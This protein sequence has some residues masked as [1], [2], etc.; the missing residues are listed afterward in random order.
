MTAEHTPRYRDAQ[1]NA[2]MKDLRRDVR[3][4]PHLRRRLDQ[5][6][7]RLASVLRVVETWDRA[8]ARRAGE[9]LD[10]GCIAAANTAASMIFDADLRL[11]WLR[12]TM[13][14]ADDGAA[15]RIAAALDQDREVL[16]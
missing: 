2:L 10:Q 6:E 11:L 14:G 7:S 16:S 15:E 5:V 12:Q 13:I 3:D 9:L 8:H 1:L 4:V